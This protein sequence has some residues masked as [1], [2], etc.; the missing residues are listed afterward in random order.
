MAKR[1]KSFPLFLLK[2]LKRRFPVGTTFFLY[3]YSI[4]YY[5]K[6]VL[7]RYNPKIILYSGEA[8]AGLDTIHAFS[9]DG[10]K[11]YFCVSLEK[12]LLREVS[13]LEIVVFTKNTG[14][15]QLTLLNEPR[16]KGTVDRRRFEAL[17]EDFFSFSYFQRTQ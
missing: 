3:D 5:I 17:W 2:K 4:E 13:L 14:D 12:R 7:F 11:Y 10:V 16:S 6:E 9:L 15:S 1:E 8:N